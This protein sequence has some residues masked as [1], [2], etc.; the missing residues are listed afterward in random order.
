MKIQF[1]GPLSVSQLPL[2]APALDSNLLPMN[3]LQ[4]CLDFP[5]RRSLQV[6][7][8]SPGAE[9][10]QDRARAPEGLTWVPLPQGLFALWVGDRG[11]LWE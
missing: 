2:C 1:A 8:L 11:Q 4:S 5:R 3:P 9:Q 7:S 10:P 6:S